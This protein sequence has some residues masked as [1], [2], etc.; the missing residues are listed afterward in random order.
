MIKIENIN[1]SG[2]EAAIRGMRMPFK[3]HDK[4]DSLFYADGTFSLGEQ[5]VEL[6]KKLIRGGSEHRK[7]LR[8]IHISM[9]ITAPSYWIAEQDTYKV[10]TA[11]NSSS[12]MHIGMKKEFTLND[13]TINNEILK[14]ADVL[15]LLNN[16]IETINN[17]RNKYNKTYNFDY[18]ESIRQLLPSGYN[19]TYTYDC[20]ME[21]LLNMCKQRHGH[22]LPEWREFI[23]IMIDRVPYFREWYNCLK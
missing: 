8:F 9:D 15:G 12:F 13:F 1:Y 5:D 11:R 6:S 19:Y 22:R 18:F 17:L 3:S 21:T 7:F 23:A 10:A 2:Y 4:S 14:D 16:T 20:S